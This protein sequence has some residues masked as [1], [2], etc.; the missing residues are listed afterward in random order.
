MAICVT[1]LPEATWGP[2]GT[3]WGHHPFDEG[4]LIILG[5]Q[6]DANCWANN[7]QTWSH[8]LRLCPFA[9]AL[10]Q[11][12]ICSPEILWQ[13]S[14]LKT[15][16]KWKIMCGLSSLQARH[17]V[18]NWPHLQALFIDQVCMA[19]AQSLD[20]WLDV[21][22]LERMTPTTY[23]HLW[24]AKHVF[25]SCFCQTLK[26]SMSKHVKTA[27]LTLSTARAHVL[28]YPKVLKKPA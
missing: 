26:T 24:N 21:W 10:T 20:D 2:C 3:N 4:E 18:Q 15:P 23:D 1:K 25:L 22:D 11:Q 17:M 9:V 13:I 6:V 27:S 7:V 19:S 5:L 16:V 8:L 14:Q 28:K 12:M